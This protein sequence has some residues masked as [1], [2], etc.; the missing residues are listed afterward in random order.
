MS[1]RNHDE[2]GRRTK[3]KPV[4]TLPNA[5]LCHVQ[6]SEF[7]GYV[8]CL[9]PDSGDCP[10]ALDHANGALCLHPQNATIAA[11]PQGMPGS[12][13][14]KL[15]LKPGRNLANLTFRQAT[16]DDC[17][18]L[19][20][21]NYHLIH[22]LGLPHLMSV[23][24]MGKRM[25]KMLAFDH[26]AILFEINGKAVAYALYRESPHDIYL[27]QFLVIRSHRRRGIARRALGML[28]AHVWSKTKGLTVEV[29]VSNQRAL[30]FWRKAGY[31]DLSLKLEIPPL[32]Q[33]NKKGRADK[34]VA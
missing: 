5:H 33:R 6:P 13:S 24:E 15:T 21:L 31:T 4:Q 10:H 9:V 19:G 1:R 3:P 16:K 30:E 12:Q 22:D 7:R 29:L 2:G 27:R 26:R 23:P 32:R 8:D 11:K 17:E 34:Q 25:R 20:R 18:L 28:R 14:S